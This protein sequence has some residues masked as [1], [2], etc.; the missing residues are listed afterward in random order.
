M[1]HVTVPPMLL[2]TR[3]AV[4]LLVTHSLVVIV[5]ADRVLLIT[6]LEPTRR[7]TLLLIIGSAVSAAALRL[8]LVVTVTVARLLLLLLLLLLLIA[9]A[10][11]IETSS[12]TQPSDAFC[13][14][15]NRV[16]NYLNNE[17]ART[18]TFITVGYY[19]GKC[20]CK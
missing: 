18:C 19:G 10:T 1:A 7:C 16:K 17:P 2:A 14:V 9:V 12:Q 13:G 11:N 3:R 8:L 15:Y 5:E 20:E 6:G 4:A